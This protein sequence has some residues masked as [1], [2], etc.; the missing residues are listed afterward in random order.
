MLTI[1][2]QVN[3]VPVAFMNSYQDA[4]LY[5]FYTKSKGFSLNNS[6][7]RKNQF[8][9]WNVEQQ[10]REKKIILISNF[11][12]NNWD[13]IVNLPNTKYKVIDNFQAY[14][15]IKIIPNSIKSTALLSEN[16]SVNIQLENT[17]KEIIDLEK[18]IEF[19]PVLYYQFFEGKYPIK[20]VKVSK[21]FNSSLHNSINFDI[22]APNRSGNFTL[23]FSI[24]AGWLPTS[25]NSDKF[26]IV[27]K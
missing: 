9:I 1:Y 3:N 7:G 15:K 20:I 2:K 17:Q 19:A 27:I 14:S 4:S 16:I 13:S 6:W 23:S 5:E 26:K 21:I 8:D 22:I 10:Y 11:K 24:K 25:I 12:N 18:S